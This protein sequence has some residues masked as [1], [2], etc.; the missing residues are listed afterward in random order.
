MKPAKL[1]GVVTAFSGNGRKFGYPT[2][3]INSDTKLDDGVYFG[4]ADLDDYTN[5]PAV[6]FVGTPT[7]VGDTER[8]VE[9]HLLDI[10]DHDYY[11]EL[12]TLTLK[13]YHR[14]NK[15]FK[16]VEI[17]KNVMAEDDAVAREWFASSGKDRL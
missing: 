7:T 3:N 17:L 13:H 15:T 2:A 4:F 12:L 14:P 6:I 10:P 16:D 5:H 9:A 8:R 11:G 1:E